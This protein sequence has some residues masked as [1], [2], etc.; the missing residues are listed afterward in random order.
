[1][2]ALDHS[3]TTAADVAKSCGT[4]APVK[5]SSRSRKFGKTRLQKQDQSKKSM[6]KHEDAEEEIN[7]NT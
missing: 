6:K 5:K 3:Y 7:E 2:R 4:D 1:L